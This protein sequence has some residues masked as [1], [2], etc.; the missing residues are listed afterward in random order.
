MTKPV[1]MTPRADRDMNEC[2]AWLRR[3]NHYAAARFLESAE[4]TCK[5]LSTLPA[6]GSRCYTG[7]ELMEGIRFIPIRNWESYLLFFRERTDSI[8][9]IRLLHDA[10]AIP[11]ILKS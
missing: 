1:R 7:I 3:E 5:H 4:L 8:D 10:R 11:E 2:F 6:A 9:I